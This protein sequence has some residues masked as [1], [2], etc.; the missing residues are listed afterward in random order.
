MKSSFWSQDM[1]LLKWPVMLLVICI[2]ASAVWCGSA[3]KF[4]EMATLATQAAQANR[5]QAAESV[6]KIEEEAATIRSHMDQYRDLQTRGIIGNEE[7]LQLVEALGRIR[8]RHKLYS[9]QFDIAQQA[10]MPLRE[11]E[12]EDAGPWLS[13]RSSQI[14][15]VL[16]LLHEEDLIRLLEELRSV[17]RGMFVVEECSLSRANTEVVSELLKLNENLQASC[18]ILWLTL[19]SEEQQAGEGLE[20]APPES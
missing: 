9:I 14:R 18:T 20:A 2:A 13:L 19:K 3:Y 11:G 7:R 10:V 6:R 4:R 5:E 8:E 1:L 12:P 15:I 16:S 17:G